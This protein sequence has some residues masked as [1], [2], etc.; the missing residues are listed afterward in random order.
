M[1]VCL[2]GSSVEIC[3]HL[4]PDP[5]EDEDKT[6]R[7]TCTFEI[8]HHNPE[9]ENSIIKE[10]NIPSP[11]LAN[12]VTRQ[13]LSD[14]VV[15]LRSRPVLPILPNDTS[16][17]RYDFVLT[18]YEG[19]PLDEPQNLSPEDE[20][21]R[22]PFGYEMEL[23]REPTLK[24]LTY[25]AT[26]ILRDSKIEFFCNPN[27]L[28]AKHVTGYLSSWGM[29]VEHH[30]TEA[31]K[32]EEI[33]TKNDVSK[34]S[35]ND[36]STNT[37]S[38][39]SA[40]LNNDEIPHH[41]L[42][43]EKSRF[44]EGSLN[45]DDEV[46]EG[47]EF[48]I[49]DDDIQTFKSRLNEAKLQAINSYHKSLASQTKQSDLLTRRHS[50]RS[51][52]N[53]GVT[54]EVIENYT[55]NK[56]NKK[57]T[58]EHHQRLPCF[59]HFT[60][61]DN[62]K[63]VIDAVISARAPLDSSSNDHNINFE[64]P[65]IQILPKPAGPRRLLTALHTAIHKPVVD[66]HFKP[67]ATTPLSPSIFSAT[68]GPYPSRLS[69]YSYSNFS[70]PGRNEESDK[71][72]LDI[73]VRDSIHDQLSQKDTLSPSQ[74]SYPRSSASNSIS[75]ANNNNNATSPMDTTAMNYFSN[76]AAQLGDG[77]KGMVIQSHDGRA[78]GL[79]FN[80]THSPMEEGNEDDNDNYEEG[81]KGSNLSHSLGLPP[82]SKRTRRPSAG[83]NANTN[84]GLNRGGSTRRAA[85]Y[86]PNI[87]LR[88]MIEKV[89]T[90]SPNP[91]E[92]D[93]PKSNNLISRASTTIIDKGENQGRPD[94]LSH[95][96]SDPVPTLYDEEAP[97]LTSLPKFTFDDTQVLLE[98]QQENQNGEHL[99]Q[100][101][102]NNFR[103]KNNESHI[104]EE[105]VK[106]SRPST[107]KSEDSAITMRATSEASSATISS[108][109]NISS[110]YSPSIRASNTNPFDEKEP[111][112]RS[113]GE[114]P[115]LNT[116]QRSRSVLKSIKD[117]A[118]AAR[119]DVESKYNDNAKT[120]QTSNIISSGWLNGG[121][122]P[123]VNVLIV[124]G[125]VAFILITIQSVL[126]YYKLR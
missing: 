96:H 122:T 25:C 100:Q 9:T 38:Y 60:S 89:S 69:S 62:Y 92:D 73:G 47:T 49:I 112:A 105:S 74:T 83:A 101:K 4:V 71:S 6:N 104:S 99:T 124:E 52:S 32:S 26:Q 42:E 34:V 88:E 85:M 18:L 95:S 86:K 48:V 13:I 108:N 68:P 31:V 7:L 121:I 27:S 22:Q 51:N 1:H 14:L 61:L 64:L 43:N 44:L 11:F 23:A 72:Q 118:Q 50:I 98:E 116:R 57:S 78:A 114:R 113:P 103:K 117:A 126:I 10:K 35:S 39:S 59:L 91:D 45:Q 20:A 70:F 58:S 87:G 123:P 84:I 63:V 46:K 106:S 8:Y 15:D 90:K 29:L 36:L 93:E 75:S 109:L 125:K 81:F 67:L 66:P 102:E 55:D 41:S 107:S 16:K 19:E 12:L 3:L 53:S 56:P 120:A 30:S 65:N 77:N 21:T 54:P 79:F 80:P 76:K 82:K 110:S 5:Y 17:R 37:E 24:E 40:D 115:A 2:P 33:S 119:R 94:T 97:T 28:F 111:S